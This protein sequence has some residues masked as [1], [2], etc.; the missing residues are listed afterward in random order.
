MKQK[1]KR[2]LAVLRY[3]PWS[4]Y[5]NFHYLPLKQ[6]LKLPVL[7]YKPELRRC[8]GTVIIESDYIR[9]GMIRLGF[10]QGALFPDSGITWDNYGGKVVFR[11]RCTIGNAS[12]IVVRKTGNIVFGNRFMATC[13]FKLYSCYQIVFEEKVRFGWD[14]IVVDSSLHKIKDMNNQQ[15]GKGFAPILFG[16]NNWISSRCFVLQG[17]KTPDYC[18]FGAGSILNKDYSSNPTHILMAGNPLTVKKQGIW[19]DLADDALEYEYVEDILEK[20]DSN[21]R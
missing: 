1:I 20:D 12:A 11:G 6:A 15:V 2:T 14:S 21:Y 4:I 13:S 8:K 5:F 17:T 16:K 18:I 10:R 7:L 9:R 19:R 3:L